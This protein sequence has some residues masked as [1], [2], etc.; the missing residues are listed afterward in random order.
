M[1]KFL[2]SIFGI[3]LIGVLLYILINVYS[4][5]KLQ[6]FN[7]F[8]KAELNI[9]TSEF[10]RD[11]NVQYTAGVDSYRISSNEMNDAT[12]YKTLEVEQN[13]PYKVT[14]MV[15]TKDVV[16]DN[17]VSE[18]GAH[19]SIID[20]VEKSRSVIG[21]EDWQKLEFYFNSYARKSVNI[22]FR[23]GGY[24]DNA[25]GTV[26]FSDFKVE[27]GSKNTDNDWRVACFIVPT[28]DLKMNDGE[29]IKLK[30]TENDIYNVN[31]NMQRFKQS[32]NQL[33]HGAI[34]VTYDIINTEK[35]VTSMS[36][37][38]KNGHYISGKNVANIIDPYLSKKAYD[39]IFVV[40]KIETGNIKLNNEENDWIGLGGMMYK[41]IG[42]SDIRMLEKYNSIYQ[43]DAR[44]NRFPEEV[45]VHEFLHDLER[46]GF[47]ME[48]E[49]P[50]LHDYK[51]YGYENEAVI[52][53][54]IWYGDYMSNDIELLDGKNI[55][56]NPLIYNNQPAN[57]EN[58]T[59]SMK[60]DFIKEPDN[61]IE[62]LSQIIN[63]NYEIIT[64]KI[65]STET[66]DALVI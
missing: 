30:M 33:S 1:R 53:Q 57:A 6:Y 11:K 39:H 19:I 27:K 31:T 21:T 7:D 35:T 36:F 2:K 5:Y 18:S 46:I 24:E 42:F 34:D 4:A 63:R 60:I 41:G 23:L 14:C 38:K 56:L 44:T 43:Y 9:Y 64:N 50:K 48:F 28:T 66:V 16:T 13:T 15:K 59:F 8:N 45:M 26:W 55:G 25:S 58:F 20:T 17:P 65:K 32:C 51:K 62:E 37:D 49:T 54:K 29:V 3:I 47:S 22:G 61:I 40:A 52:G 12:L 10:M